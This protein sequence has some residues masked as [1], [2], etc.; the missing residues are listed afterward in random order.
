MK[1]ETPERSNILNMFWDT[2]TVS[3]GWGRKTVMQ[4][5]NTYVFCKVPP[6]FNKGLPQ[7]IFIYY[8]EN[9]LEQVIPIHFLKLLF[10]KEFT[11]S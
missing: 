6:G 4:I 1:A 3:W 2:F 9:T 10:L 7:L 5:S 8:I 11:A